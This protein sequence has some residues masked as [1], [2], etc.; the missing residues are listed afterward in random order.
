MARSK[1]KPA[2]TANSPVSSKEKLP[3][4]ILQV[5][6]GPNG[7]IYVA[8]CSGV[9]ETE[10]MLALSRLAQDADRTFPKEPPENPRVVYLP[11]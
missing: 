7:H 11:C 5:S 2:E 4:P 3:K 8:K 6:M 9:S 1:N 10:Y